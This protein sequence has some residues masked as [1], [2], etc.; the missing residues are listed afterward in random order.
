MVNFLP[1]FSAS[2]N[3]AAPLQGLVSPSPANLVYVP[4]VMVFRSNSSKISSAFLLSHKSVTE[5]ESPSTANAALDKVYNL[6]FIFP[7]ARAVLP[8]HTWTIRDG[9][10]FEASAFVSSIRGLRPVSHDFPH[11]RLPLIFPHFSVLFLFFAHFLRS[12]SETLPFSTNTFLP[13]LPHTT[14]LSPYSPHHPDDTPRP[15]SDYCPAVSS[16]TP[17]LPFSSL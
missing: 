17:R 4:Y 9:I 2:P 6:Y 14:E 8:F 3:R 12:C 10:G 5:F 15:L 11:W 16:E 1:T 13:T 7:R